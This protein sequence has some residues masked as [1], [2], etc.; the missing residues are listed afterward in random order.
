MG[1]CLFVY[2]LNETSWLFFTIELTFFHSSNNQSRNFFRHFLQ[3]IVL[4]QIRYQFGH[5]AKYLEDSIPQL[6]ECGY[7]LW[8]TQI[9]YFTVAILVYFCLN[10]IKAKF[11][12]CKTVLG[13]DSS[14]LVRSELFWTGHKESFGQI[15]VIMATVPQLEMPAFGHNTDNNT[16]N[17]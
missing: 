10:N 6:E 12:L 1:L 2:W 8:V 15:L 5:G 4:D 9:T 17:H 7:V 16:K 13:Q 3:P 14:F 11:V